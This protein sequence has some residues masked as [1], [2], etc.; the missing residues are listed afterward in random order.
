M[1]IK[2]V[3]LVWEYAPAAGN[4]LLLLLAIA[5]QAN[6]L[7]AEAWPSIDTLARRTRLNPRTVQRLLRKLVSAG[8][9]CIEPGGGRRS[10]TYRIDLS[11]LVKPPPE[12]G[13]SDGSSVMDRHLRQDATPD[14]A[15]TPGVVKYDHPTPDAAAPPDPSRTVLHPPGV[16]G[17]ATADPGGDAAADSRRIVQ[18]AHQR[19]P[20]SP[21][22]R[23][24]LEDAVFEALSIG[25]ASR[26]VQDLVSQNLDGAYSPAAVMCARIRSL[27]KSSPAVPTAA[28][29][30]AWCGNCDGPEPHRRWIQLDD[31]RVTACPA[32]HPRNNIVPAEVSA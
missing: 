7:G 25:H 24:R 31:N 12:R 20:M 6:D 1:S 18:L 11:L 23:R 16:A 13:T 21:E 3:T 28:A 32:C 8:L 15:T 4:E 26:E 9:L 22:N 14:T 2:V 10:N 19:H 5:D 29:R 30:P 17:A 27:M